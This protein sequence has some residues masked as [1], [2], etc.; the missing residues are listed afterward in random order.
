LAIMLFLGLVSGYWG[1]DIIDNR[2]I[3]SAGPV[4]VFLSGA[5]LL[6]LIVWVLIKAGLRDIEVAFYLSENGV[7]IIPS[8]RQKRLDRNI[9]IL[10]RILFLLTL[11]GGQWS[12]WQPYSPWKSVRGIEINKQAREILISGGSW[13]I[14]LVCTRDN[15]TQA[16]ELV[17]EKGVV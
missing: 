5:W 8:P 13:D 17:M 6:F 1:A 14:R 15:F 4:L 2:G 16:L 3:D 9:G 10:S 11:K 12:A 7:G